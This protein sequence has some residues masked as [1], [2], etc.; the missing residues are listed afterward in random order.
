VQHVQ[1][2]AV[3]GKNERKKERKNEWMKE[4]KKEC[5]SMPAVL[6][7][8]DR[9]PGV[10]WR[11]K[12]ECSGGVVVIQIQ[13]ASACQY[14]STMQKACIVSTSRPWSIQPTHAMQARQTHRRCDHRPWCLT[15]WVGGHQHKQSSTNW[16]CHRPRSCVACIWIHMYVAQCN[17]RHFFFLLQIPNLI[18]VFSHTTS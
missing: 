4:R 1:C 3:Q 16:G 14:P 15:A 11:P 6:E 7:N 9:F 18:W 10:M 2:N 5:S 13:W 17:P 8:W 12:A